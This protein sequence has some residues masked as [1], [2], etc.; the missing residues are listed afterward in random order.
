MYD[1]LIGGAG[2]AGA[3]LAARLSED[4]AR[5][6][7]LIEAGPDYLQVDQLPPTVRGFAF[8][9]RAYAGRR[10]LSHEWHYTARATD[11]YPRMPVPRGRMIGGS[12]SVNGAVFLR[13][14]RSDLDHWAAMGNPTWSYADCLPYYQKVETD[15]DFG[16][17]EVH[18]SG[19]PI[20]V[21]RAA[22]PNW[23]PPSEAFFEAC[24]ELGYTYCDDMN[25]PD[26]RGVGPIPTNYHQG[27]RH[28]SAI[29]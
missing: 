3:V 17:A 5:T 6:V 12:S 10:L 1:T 14:L 21:Q 22:R 28:S 11:Q 15:T 19:G 18:G 16:H 27:I 13:A 7:C 2:S 4:P 24:T 29:A 25:R 23:L 20:P 8:T 9:D 26:A